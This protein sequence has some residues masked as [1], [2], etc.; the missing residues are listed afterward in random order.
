MP[1]NK[2]TRPSQTFLHGHRGIHLRLLGGKSKSKG[3]FVFILWPKR[4]TL[5]GGLNGNDE[6]RPPQ[7][8]DYGP[9]SGRRGRVSKIDEKSLI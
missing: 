9:S 1:R 5:I 4:S 2:Y 6:I 3:L 8:H 7:T